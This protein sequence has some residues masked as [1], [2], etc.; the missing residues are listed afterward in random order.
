[1]RGEGGCAI[2]VV[3]GDLSL[4][5]GVFSGGRRCSSSPCQHNGVCED[6]IRS[7]TCTCTE[8]YEGKNCAFG[9][10]LLS[11][12]EAL[13]P[14]VIGVPRKPYT[15]TAL[16]L[17][18]VIVF[19]V[20][21]HSSWQSRGDAC[22][23]STEPLWNPEVTQVASS[24]EPPFSSYVGRGLKQETACPAAVPAGTWPGEPG[25]PCWDGFPATPVPLRLHT[26]PGQS[27]GTEGLQ[28]TTCFQWKRHKGKRILPGM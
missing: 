8:G 19:S 12:W 9:K 24:P 13:S 3:V 25:L 28:K 2:W 23:L 20:K 22:C 17:Q 5:R 15:Y 7:Y 1:M 26:P 6:S 27:L 10:A 16:P 21:R 14:P 18:P 11:F 4:S